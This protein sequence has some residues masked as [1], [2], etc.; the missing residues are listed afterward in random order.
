MP[1]LDSASLLFPQ[2]A[3]FV[4]NWN[5][6]KMY[7]VR[8]LA[9]RRDRANQYRPVMERL[10][11]RELLSFRPTNVLTYHN[12]LLRTGANLTESILRPRNVHAGSFGLLYSYPVDG[13]IYATPL[14]MDGLTL[15]DGSVHN[16]VFVATEHDSVYAFDANGGG[17]LWQD[18]FIDPANGISTFTTGDAL[19]CGQISPEIGIT[20]TPVI[21][22][23][24]GIMYVV[25][26]FKQVVG[27][28]T[29]YHQQLHALD[30]TTGDDVIDPVEIQASVI[31]DSGH[32]VTFNPR[33]YKERAALTLVN[34]VLYTAWA[35]HCDIT[36]SN[37][38]V[39]G[40]DPSSLQ[41]VSVFNTSPNG[42]LDTIWQGNGGLASDGSA[43]Y[44]ETGNGTDITGHGDDYSEAFMKL[45]LADG[46]TVDDYFIP[47]NFHALDQ[48]DRDIGSGAPIALPDQPGDH[49][50][51]LVGGGKD[52]RIFLMDR[53]N[54]GGLNNPPNGPDLVLQ[55]VPNA[56]SGG[57][58]DTPAYFDAGD[59]NGPFIY[60]V[61]NGDT[62]KAFQL[63]NG[64]LTTTPTSHSRNR[65]SGS[66]GATP[67]ITAKGT[68]HGILWALENASGH[69]VLH[70]YDATNLDTELYNSNQVSSDQ[71]PQG[72][73][74]ASPSAADGEVFVPTSN[75]LAIFGLF[76]RA[77]M[78]P[79]ADQA[80][81]STDAGALNPALTPA[82]IA[83]LADTRSLSQSSILAAPTLSRLADSG[84]NPDLA[85]PVQ[86][87]TRS[88]LSDDP[89]ST[90]PVLARPA[91][92]APALVDMTIA[93]LSASDDL[94]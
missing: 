78:S 4:M 70:A 31:N 79:Q 23:N 51:L 59:P 66:Y 53:D 26:Q 44:F 39:I 55:T 89:L 82:V 61:G 34:G 49:P 57:S 10:E 73:K 9:S 32:T 60:Y 38:W 64:L 16:V 18:S 42:S 87:D 21:D 47:A 91:A 48:A 20:A 35:S 68:K 83:G 94:S 84:I 67:I 74:F 29:T 45:D 2:G 1:I 85:N 8:R 76:G 13:Q 15:P 58:W 62:A 37:G 19:G 92:M 22:P 25:D 36:P 7:I 3:L 14:Y 28:T 50:H 56:L 52:G 12:D 65:F 5:R 90:H 43:L 88:V 86:T 41:Q 93:L 40:Y 69:A 46:Q 17:L 71:L 11:S 30:V 33:Y 63:V 6:W 80:D 77:G 81:D 72:V 27:T 54:M 75:S 24:T